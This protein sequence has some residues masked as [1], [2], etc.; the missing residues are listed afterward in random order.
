MDDAMKV[1]RLQERAETLRVLLVKYAEKDDDADYA[2]RLMEPFFEEI[3]QGK[4]VPPTRNIHR[5]YF[6]HTDEPLYCKYKDLSEAAAEYS[7]VLEDWK[8]CRE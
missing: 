6:A 5:R 7:C 2:L 1:R 4:I 3:R 8:E